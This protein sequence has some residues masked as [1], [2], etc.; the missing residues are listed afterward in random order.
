MTNAIGPLL[1]TRGRHTVIRTEKKLNL[2]QK[3]TWGAET[4]KRKKK[5]VKK[6]ERNTCEFRRHSP[7]A[8]YPFCPVVVMRPSSSVV[9]AAAG[10][11]W[12]IIFLKKRKKAEGIKK[13]KKNCEL[14]RHSPRALYPLRPVVLMGTCLSSAVAAAAAAWSKWVIIIKKQKKAKKKPVSSGGIPPEHCT[15][16]ALLL[17]WNR[18]RPRRWRRRILVSSE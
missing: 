2:K 1:V 15:L 18:P 8:L 17:W 16:S 4:N 13:E 11:K 7:W 12:V 6:N 14:R 3:H 9:A 5:K 10:S